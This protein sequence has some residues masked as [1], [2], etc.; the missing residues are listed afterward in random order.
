M[1]VVHDIGNRLRIQQSSA[2]ANEDQ[3]R[4]A[5]R[6]Q[7]PSTNAVTRDNQSSQ[8]DQ[9]DNEFRRMKREWRTALFFAFLMLFFFASWVPIF[10]AD[11][12][13]YFR[14]YNIHQDVINF[15]VFLSHFNSAFNPFLYTIKADFRDA[16]KRRVCSCFAN[17]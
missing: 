17:R 8:E 15:F 13:I 3:I 16:L 9:H 6:M 12:L 10:F 1:R 2:A 5:Q 14:L 7:Q 4:T 11:T